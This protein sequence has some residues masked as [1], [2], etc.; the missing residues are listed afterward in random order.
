MANTPAGGVVPRCF[1]CGIENEPIIKHRCAVCREVRQGKV[2]VVEPAMKF[3]VRQL[4]HRTRVGWVGMAGCTVVAVI[5]L[6]EGSLTG[7]LWALAALT[8]ALILA[9]VNLRHDLRIRDLTREML[10]MYGPLPSALTKSIPQT[11]DRGRRL[12]SG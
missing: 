7:G 9:V 10:D 11:R 4:E 2:A 8:C 6:A 12:S 5:G 3:E 1:D